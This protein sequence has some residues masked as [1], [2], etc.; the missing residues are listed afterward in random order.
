M[1]RLKVFAIFI[2]LKSMAFSQSTF[3]TGGNICKDAD[4]E[5]VFQDE[6]NVDTLNTDFWMT[7]F[8]CADWGEQCEGSR[9]D[10]GDIHLDQNVVISDG[11]LKLVAKHETAIWYSQTR[12]YSSGLIYSKSRYG[13]GKYELYGKIPSG[14]GLFPTFWLFGGDGEGHASEIDVFEILGD[15]P[16]KYHPGVISYD[17]TKFIDQQDCNFKDVDF[18]L[19][20]HLYSVE[21]DPFIITYKIDNKKVYEI[22]RLYTLSGRQVT[23]CCVEPGIY[24]ILPA[25]PKGKNI[26]LSIIARLAILPGSEGPNDKTI[27]PAEYVIDYVRFYKRDTLIASENECTITLFPNPTD[28]KLYIRKNNLTNI[29]I[30]NCFGQEVRSIEASGD[31]AEIDVSNLYQGVY[32]ISVNSGTDILSGKFIK[33]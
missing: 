20:F 32:F 2:L 14:K 31:D 25:Y 21:W 27:F 5:L 22:S 4:W 28:S 33:K 1:K 15:E 30:T 11:K 10:D 23:W 8:P 29:K 24:T 19:D 3:F 16:N 9:V 18:S 7:Y 6:F 13:Y 12:E 17:G 26:E